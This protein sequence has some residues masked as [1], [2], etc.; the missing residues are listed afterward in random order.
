MGVFL[1]QLPLRVFF[2]T[3][4]RRPLPLSTPFD[5]RFTFLTLP[6]TMS[7]FNRKR[8]ASI[9]AAPLA[10]QLRHDK[11]QRVPS[12]C[13]WILHEPSYKSWKNWD[14]T[15]PSTLWIHGPAGSGKSFLARFIADDLQEI[16]TGDQS[17]VTSCYCDATSTPVSMLRSVFSQLLAKGSP[18]QELKGRLS[19]AL[20]EMDKLLSAPTSSPPSESSFR[21][22]DRFVEI[23]EVAPP[24]TLIIDGLDELATKY[25]AAHEFNMAGRL[26]DL[27]GVPAGCI[28]LL[29]LSRPD[30][31][32]RKALGDS[33]D[34]EVT[35]QKTRDDLGKFVGFQISQ[36]PAL[37]A[38]PETVKSQ[39]LAE[40]VHRAE[41]IFVW[42][43]LSLQMLSKEPVEGDDDPTRVLRQLDQLP[44]A[45]DHLYAEILAKHTKILTSSELAL[46]DAVLRWA[47]LAVRPLRVVEIANALALETLHFLP[48]SDGK[49][50]LDICNSLIKIENG[51]VL[52][53][54]HS[55]RE[56]LQSTSNSKADGRREDLV[57]RAHL[58]IAKTLLSY[59]S[60]PALSRNLKDL[61]NDDNFEPTH[62]L[63]EYASLY[64]VYHCSQSPADPD[65]QNQVLSFFRSENAPV[66]FDKL[67]PQAIHRS[68]LHVPPRPSINARFCHLITLKSQLCSCFGQIRKKEMDTELSA[69]LRSAYEGF[70]DEATSTQGNHSMARTRRLVELAELYSWLPG[71]HQDQVAGILTEAIDLISASSSQEALDLKLTAQ[72][73]LADEYKRRAMFDDARALLETIVTTTATTATTGNRSMF[74]LD[75]L[76]WISSRVGDNEAAKRYLEQALAIAEAEHG[77][78]SPVTLRSRVT[79]AEVLSKLGLH[80]EAEELCATLEAQV[81]HHKT[82][83]VPLPKDS[84]SQLNTLAS[85]YAQ[86]GKYGDARE[87]YELIVEDRKNI[88]GDSHRLTLWAEMQLGIV[89]NKSGAEEK[90]RELLKSLLP[91]QEAV[92]G[93]DHP[94]VRQV[95][96]ILQEE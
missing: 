59:L 28:R 31:S 78:G 84:V 10:E 34:I 55:L 89:M 76:G 81:K 66:W 29:V 71:S 63:A 58:A 68:V 21:F 88:F 23:I 51:V 96:E 69:C 47:C 6:V 1:Y 16:G 40:L 70:L 75:S 48:S 15:L 3:S 41:G 9:L 87:L 92:L 86:Q 73:A 7:T 24:I 74:A 4:L 19:T 32:I 82:H 53:M 25:L 11:K 13:E 64:W 2:H 80:R 37:A 94:D 91:R 93:H 46:R 30:T 54:H 5:P 56:Y 8:Q 14:E 45:L 77:S 60:H 43:S 72:Q 44:S 83:G 22:W 35:Q 52:P 85:V 50:M 17:I 49:E 95:R 67:L 38:L 39:L 26:V 27:T 33:P 20:Q 90:A 62:P 79:L 57:S 65:L 18:S 42:A 36:S 61:A 12:T